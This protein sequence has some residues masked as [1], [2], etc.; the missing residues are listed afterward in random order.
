[1]IWCLT[2][3]KSDSVDVTGEGDAKI[4]ASDATD[5]TDKKDDSEEETSD[6]TESP[7]TTDDE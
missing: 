4:E 6:D 7:E 5:T 1:M 2:P 3:I